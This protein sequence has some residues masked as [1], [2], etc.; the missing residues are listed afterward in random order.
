[1][2]PIVDVRS[3]VDR[4][5]SRRP[6]LPLPYDDVSARLLLAEQDVDII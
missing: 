5:R 1:M 4:E 2:S 3:A 6:A